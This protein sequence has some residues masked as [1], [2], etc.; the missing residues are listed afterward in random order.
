[1]AASEPSVDD[2]PKRLYLKH[3]IRQLS[4]EVTLKNKKLKVLKVM[5]LLVYC[6]ILLVS[7][8]ISLLIGQKFPRKYSPLIRQ[9]AL[10]LHFFSAK[11]YTYV[12]QQ[13]NIIL[14]HPRTLSKWYSHLNAAPGFTLEALKIL[15][16][17]V[18][19][20][21]H[22]LYYSLMIDEMAWLFVSI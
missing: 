9:Y 14:P 7:I 15:S 5:M 21:I 1:V 19:S 16:L 20:S 2:T 13:F 6:W 11:A 8:K 4:H 12:R 18:N 17:K 10:S 3:E 22:P